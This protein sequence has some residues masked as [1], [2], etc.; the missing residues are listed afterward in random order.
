MLSDEGTK[1]RNKP[2]EERNTFSYVLFSTIIFTLMIV[3]P[4]FFIMLIFL[5]GN[6]LIA[7]LII[8]IFFSPIFFGFLF[9]QLPYKPIDYNRKAIK[10]SILHKLYFLI[11]SPVFIFGF[12]LSY[13]FSKGIATVYFFSFNVISIIGTFFF[14][15]FSLFIWI[16]VTLKLWE[17]K[18]GTDASQTLRLR[19]NRSKI[20]VTELVV[21]G[22][23]YDDMV[24][25]DKI[26]DSDGIDLTEMDA[27]LQEYEDNDERVKFPQLDVKPQFNLYYDKLFG[28]F[29]RK[30]N[31][32][33]GKTSII[34]III[35]PGLF[36]FLFF[37]INGSYTLSALIFFTIVGIPVGLFVIGLISV[38]G[39]FNY[40]SEK[41]LFSNMILACQTNDEKETLGTE[42]THFEAKEKSRTRFDSL[43]ILLYEFF[44][45][46][47]LLSN[48]QIK[49]SIELFVLI[50]RKINKKFH[51]FYEV[52]FQI[53]KIYLKIGYR[54]KS[55]SFFET[56]Y[57][58]FKK[59]KY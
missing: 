58:G 6:P 50:S 48:N 22:Q 36:S 13:Y 20:D 42:L 59:F 40:T 31:I 15:S 35:I 32:P 7:L 19:R 28:Q 38:L 16:S 56:A 49:E 33:F 47:Y 9:G 54:E 12:I 26:Q 51:L 27:L 23:E 4:L 39:H 18:Q 52:Y 29:L 5:P 34:G 53:G 55:L 25:A 30:K 2:I 46:K 57:N 45:A 1:K 21:I 11:T 3:L 41:N 17:K 10:Q 44:K 14:S 37:N 8:V 24:H 43:E